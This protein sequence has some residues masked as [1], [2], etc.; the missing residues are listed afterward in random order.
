MAEYRDAADEIERNRTYP[1]LAPSLISH[2]LQPRRIRAAT[3]FVRPG[4][5]VLDVGCN[6][7]YLV[8]YCPTTCQVVGVDVN[9]DLVDIASAR[10]HAAYCAPAEGLPFDD[11]RFDVVHLGGVLEIV[12]D[13][14][15][16]ILEATRVA[17]RAVI[18]S[19]AH[20]DGAWG[21]SRVP[22]HSWHVRALDED[23]LRYLLALVGQIDCLGTIYAAGQEAPQVMYWNALVRKGV[24]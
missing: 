13:P 22:I 20:A 2:D 24:V 14:V 12:F 6:S 1:D 21:R 7:G 5:R 19:T 17:R 10:L 3:Q 23:Q 18:G 4:D 16:V 9:P 15:P 11:N 8:D